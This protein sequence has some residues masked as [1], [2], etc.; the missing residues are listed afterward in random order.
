MDAMCLNRSSAYPL[1][2]KIKR[3]EMVVLIAASIFCV[4]I[5]A[6][7]GI[8]PYYGFGPRID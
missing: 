7:F 6:A 3:E 2:T 5:A 4:V 1:I 8:A